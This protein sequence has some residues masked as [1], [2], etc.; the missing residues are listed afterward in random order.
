MQKK[1]P[2][3]KKGKGKFLWK[4]KE[5]TTEFYVIINHDKSSRPT[6]PTY[7][8]SCFFLQYFN[9]EFNLSLQKNELKNIKVSRKHHQFNRYL[10]YFPKYT[11][12]TSG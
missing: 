6:S 2:I 10:N 12:L 4:D 7:Y 5:L 1:T 9:I 11:L 8:L 3:Y